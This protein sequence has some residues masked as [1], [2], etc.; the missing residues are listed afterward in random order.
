MMGNP[1]DVAALLACSR[2]TFTVADCCDA[3][4]STW[5]NRQL[6]EY[7]SAAT[8]AFYPAHHLTCGEGGMILSRSHSI[9]S[10]ARSLR[11]WGR[12]CECLPNQDNRCGRRFDHRLGGVGWDH[13]FIYSHQGYNL[14]PLEPQAAILRV[15]L[16]RQDEL[17]RRRAA[18]IAVYGPAFGAGL[19]EFFIPPRTTPRGD[20]SWMAYP[21]MIRPDAGFGAPEFARALEAEGVGTRRPLGGDLT[22]QLA[23]KGDARIE[24]PYGLGGTRRIMESVVCVGCHP[25]LVS[26]D[27]ERVIE[28]AVCVAKRLRANAE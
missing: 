8:Y 4:G 6:A 14:K 26:S 10:T 13:K 20:V 24:K 25:R 27:I 19:D 23:F 7:A 22:E 16:G 3:L 2:H 9:L 12:D 28:T 1:F 18:N 17:H 5:A 21:L 11:D 15:Q